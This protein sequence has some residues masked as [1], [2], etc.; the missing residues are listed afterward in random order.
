MTSATPPATRSFEPASRA[1][2]ARAYVPQAP[3]QPV[4]L[5][6]DLNE[7]PAPRSLVASLA[8]RLDPEDLRLYPSAAALERKY[9]E[10]L[11]VRADQVLATNGG[12]EGI[13]RICRVA[14]EPGRTMVQ[15]TPTFT[16]IE[17]SA[18]L[19]GGDVVDVP[20]FDGAF[21]VEEFLDAI[22]ESTG[23][24][25]LVSPNNPTGQR[26]DTADLVRVAE[27]A[28]EVGAMVLA[29]LAY[30]EFDDED[31]TD[32]LLELPN[33]AIV[34]TMSKAFGLAGLRLGFLVSNNEILGLARAVGAPFAVSGLSASI[35]AQRLE[36]PEP[37]A[38]VDRVRTERTSLVS[39]LDALGAQPLP[40]RANFV[41]ARFPN[42]AWMADGL[43]GLGISVR[44]FGTPALDGCLRI[45]C[46]GDGRS[47]QDLE[48]ALRSAAAPQA[49]LFDLDGVIADVSRSYR[50]SIVA[51]AATYGVELNARQISEAKRRGDANND[52]VL[53][54]SLLA[55]A[56]VEATLDEATS[57]FESIYQGT[58]EAPGLRETESMIPDRTV[59]ERLAARLPLA[60]VTGRPRA[61]A[62]LFLERTGIADL[63]PVVIAMEDGPAKPAP[64]VVRL[65]MDRIGVA[66]AWMIGDTVDDVVA[67]RASGVIPLGVVPPGDD[68]DLTTDTLLRAGAARV[69]GDLSELEELLR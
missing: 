7:G 64:D 30:A 22:D 34:R 2:A 32:A 52:W 17:H 36:Q 61:D 9:A 27:R 56:G 54:R 38:Y 13:E 16:M 66:R 33:V 5:K 68:V 42:G 44:A 63:F 35:G 3:L 69:L 24:I 47:Y 67:S 29:D 41:L 23:L 46:P 53:T 43:L 49:L 31:P 59:L 14:L 60:I 65:A 12:D 6:L 39:L 48:H 62:E 19:A 25:A 51:T 15:H 26:I 40:S 21:P 10:R 58:P 8:G 57:R 28:S 45:T 1:G 20:W 50:A 37:E 11:G 4:S 18:R 55:S